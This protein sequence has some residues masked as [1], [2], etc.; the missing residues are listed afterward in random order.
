M[1]SSTAGGLVLSPSSRLD[2]RDLMLGAELLRARGD[3]L[4]GA[5]VGVAPGACIC[6]GGAGG[7]RTGLELRVELARCCG[8]EACRSNGGADNASD[9][10]ADAD[11]R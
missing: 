7:S 4:A 1:P 3:V 11:G 10:G 2:G 5:A 9:A 6:I 8:W